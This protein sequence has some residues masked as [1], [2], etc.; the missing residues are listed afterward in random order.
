MLQSVSSFEAFGFEP[1]FRLEVDPEFPGD[2][3]WDCPVFGFDRHGSVMPQF[4]SRWGTPFVIRVQRLRGPEW[5]ALFAAGGLGSLRGA[6]AT[7]APNLAVIVVDGLAYLI[8]ATAP[9]AQATIVHDQVHQVVSCDEPPLLLLVRSIDLVAVGR[10]GIA[11]S[12][13]RLCVMT[14]GSLMPTMQE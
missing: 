13:P 2:G 7:P 4:D 10:T 8:D 5:V 1:A 9:G 11:W 14:C 6:F 3:D 12:T